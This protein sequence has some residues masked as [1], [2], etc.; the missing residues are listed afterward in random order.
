MKTL[1]QTSGF[2]IIELVI[3]ITIFSLMIIS[4]TSLY[5]QTTYLGEKMRNTRYLSESAREIT[6]RIADDV[7][8]I[9]I[10]S[11]YSRY[12]DHTLLNDT[13]KNPSYQDG[14]EILTIG[15]EIRVRKTY[16]YGKYISGIL[17]RCSVLDKLDKN[18]HCGLYVMPASIAGWILS[19]SF[20]EGFNL[21]DSF[22]PEE[23]RKR[24]KLEDLTFYISWDGIHTEK[25]VTLVLTLAL[26]PRIGIPPTLVNE[27]RLH[28]QTTISERFFTLN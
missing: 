7:R 27:T 3:S 14:G 5:I 11:K 4:I 25:K 22:V 23:N 15:N 17:S 21:V 2:T 8:S 12:D 9:G 24:V 18:Q 28:V 10:S 16:F 1:R 19:P 13:W 26:M 6:E 20:S